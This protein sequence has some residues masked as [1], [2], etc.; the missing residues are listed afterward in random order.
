[1]EQERVD[2]VVAGYY[3]EITLESMTV[4]MR[5]LLHGARFVAV[6]VD[7]RYVGADGPIPGAGAF[8]KALEQASGRSPDV[9]VG[10]P[11]I[12]I[13]QEA[14]ASVGRPASECLFV[15]DNMEADVVAA[16]TAGLPALLVLTGVSSRADLEASGVAVEHVAE[17]VEVLAD[18]F[19]T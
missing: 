11:S 18:A 12:T 7:R 8:V 17:T 19:A 5:A 2:Y 4:A 14:V 3:P 16:H 9:I 1:M 6:N 13:V 10:K 15:G